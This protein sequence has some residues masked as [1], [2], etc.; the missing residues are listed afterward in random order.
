MH[1][2][3]AVMLLTGDPEDSTLSGRWRI[4]GDVGGYPVNQT[5]T[6]KQAGTL[7]TGNCASDQATESIS[8]ETVG[9]E[10]SFT[11]NSDY[12]G[13]R[14]QFTYRGTFESATRLKGRIDVQPVGAAGTFTAERV[15]PK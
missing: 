5:C 8:G 2:L 7:L 9:A 4:V 1:L 3:L 12:E 13:S 15:E 14:L 10:F 6:I 11:Q